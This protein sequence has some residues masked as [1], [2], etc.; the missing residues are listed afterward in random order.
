MGNMAK[1]ALIEAAGIF[2]SIPEQDIIEN[3]L[4]FIENIILLQ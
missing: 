4:K 3:D 1:F 2:N